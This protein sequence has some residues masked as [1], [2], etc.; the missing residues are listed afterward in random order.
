M[1]IKSSHFQ[2]IV[3]ERLSLLDWSKKNITGTWSLGHCDIFTYGGHLLQALGKFGRVGWACITRQTLLEGL[4]RCPQQRLGVSVPFIFSRYSVAIGISALERTELRHCSFSFD[5]RKS[6]GRSGRSNSA[7]FL[8]RFRVKGD[9]PVTVC[10]G[11]TIALTNSS[12]TI[13]AE[14]SQG[15]F[16]VLLAQLEF[17]PVNKANSLWM[18][19][20][21][22]RHHRRRRQDYT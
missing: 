15:P 18:V 7:R 9:R 3:L 5:G 20:H 16:F 1:K 19:V 17:V 13:S 14:G 10:R 6:V 8:R 21:R 22:L 2:T 11:A 12:G 4:R